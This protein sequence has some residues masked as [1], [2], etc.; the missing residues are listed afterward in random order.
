[1]E[2][3]LAVPVA[4]A[5]TRG[6]AA[7]LACLGL[8]RGFGR[9]EISTAEPLL[10]ESVAIARK[11]R[12][13]RELAYALLCWG[14]MC[15]YHRRP[16]TD[17]PARARA[18]LEEAATLCEEAGD[19]VSRGRLARL[20]MYQ[21]FLS[22]AVGELSS[23]EKSITRGL[24]VMKEMGDR[25]N[26]AV[27]LADL[28]QLALARDDPARACALLEESLVYN[29]AIGNRY[30]LG[31]T[32]A[33]L[34]D[35]LRRTGDRTAAQLQYAHALAELHAAGHVWQSHQALGGLASWPSRPANRRVP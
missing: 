12:A 17:D 15:A 13:Q 24:E 22:L 5:R 28:G 20:W 30:G 9:G 2:R 1:M 26:I 8:Y 11:V 6:R 21:G 32:L 23:A 18:Y 25:W 4:Q 10:A 31:G 14:V 35:T 34:G 27:G 33:Q 16:G 29:R 19:E 7:A 3:F